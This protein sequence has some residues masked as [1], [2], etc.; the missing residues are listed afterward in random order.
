MGRGRRCGPCSAGGYEDDD[1]EC[2]DLPHW[3]WRVAL[4]IGTPCV[5]NHVTP[6]CA[7]SNR[8]EYEPAFAGIFT[9]TFSVTAWPGATVAGSVVRSPSQTK[10]A[11]LC[12]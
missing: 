11:P 10:S 3:T 5:E 6:S 7:T 2:E 9:M 1:R 8:R 4:P 12:V